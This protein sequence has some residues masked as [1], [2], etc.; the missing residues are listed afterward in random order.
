MVSKGNYLNGMSA[1]WDEAGL[2]DELKR[3]P[4]MAKFIFIAILS[5]R[6]VIIEILLK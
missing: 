3:I 6:V 5:L 1:D 4:L 2:N